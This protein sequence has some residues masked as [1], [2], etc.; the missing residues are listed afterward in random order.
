M[1]QAS[2]L[3]LCQYTATL[4]R[5]AGAWFISIRWNIPGISENFSRNWVGFNNLCEILKMRSFFRKSFLVKQ[6]F[7]WKNIKTDFI[8]IL[9]TTCRSLS[10]KQLGKEGVCILLRGNLVCILFI[11]SKRIQDFLTKFG[12]SDST[13]NRNIVT[14]PYLKSET[15][16]HAQLQ[17]YSFIHTIY[18]FHGMMSVGNLHWG[19]L[20][21]NGV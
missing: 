19:Y 4:S 13:F 16:A 17:D 7:N 20:L 14:C 12:S 3:L 9:R 5:G 21:I 2:V 1:V 15:S 18:K 6:K 11:S 10:P 8:G